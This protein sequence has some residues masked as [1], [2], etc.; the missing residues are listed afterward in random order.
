MKKLLFAAAIACLSLF[1][2][3][4]KGVNHTGDKTG[5][6]YGVWALKTKTEVVETSDGP[7]TIEAD[8]TNVHFYLTL[9][10]FPFPHALAKKGSLTS[11]DLDDV[12]VDAATFTYNQDLMQISFTKKILWLTEGLSYSMRLT[13]TFDVLELTKDTFVI[14]QE[15]P[16][17]KTT[18]TY[19]YVKYK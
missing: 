3:C 8:Y 12:D 16:L 13:G 7:K 14:R 9:S 17:L 19:A 15:E 1:V 5:D 10:E 4:E 18:T 6:L 2:S 11:L